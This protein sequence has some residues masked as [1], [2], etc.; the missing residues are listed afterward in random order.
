MRRAE[1]VRGAE[2]VAAMRGAEGVAAVRV[3]AVRAVAVRA[4]ND[5]CPCLRYSGSVLERE[6]RYAQVMRGLRKACAG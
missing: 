4:V 5:V 2:R 3:A 6:K 1:G